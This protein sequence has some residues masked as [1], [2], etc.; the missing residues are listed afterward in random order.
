MNILAGK[1]MFIWKLAVCAGGNPVRLA[2]MAKDAGISTV[3]IKA[4]D[5]IDDQNQ[6]TTSWGGPNLLPAA[7][8]C[9][10]SAGIRAIGWQ[11]IYGAN[12]IGI[13]IAANEARAAIRNIQKYR[14]D[15][16]IVDPEKQYKRKGAAGWADVYMTALRSACP[17]VAIGLCSYRFPSLHPEIPWSNFLRRCDFHAPQVYWMQAHNPGDQLRRSYRELMALKSMPFIPVGAAFVEAGWQPTVAEINEFDRSAH[18][19]QLAGVSWWEWGENGQGVEYHP[20]WWA[21]ISAHDWSSS[22]PPGDSNPPQ[23]VRVRANG[24][25]IRTAPHTQ[26]TDAGDLTAGAIFDVVSETGNYYQVKAFVA[27]SVV[28]PD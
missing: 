26:G 24:T 6:G 19:L 14:F 8:D 18:E 28:D 27:K 20:E 10:R 3:I 5:G 16:W 1:T 2:E 4:A 17:D 25:N 12:L 23:R 7:V 15:G 13:S 22:A 21:A 9:L 11:Y